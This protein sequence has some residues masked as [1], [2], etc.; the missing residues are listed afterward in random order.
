MAKTE[1]WYGNCG[2]LRKL[3]EM[4]AQRLI[5]CVRGKKPDDSLFTWEDGSPV[6]DFR[7]TWSKMTKAAKVPI[8]LHDFRRSAIRNM[9]TAGV[10]E[11]T[12]IQISS[13]ATRSVF[14]RY[15]NW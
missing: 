10:S 5:P 2:Q 3:L 12:A 8:L 4:P 13:H 9:I 7:G 14:D 1:H 15:D 6:R 11:K